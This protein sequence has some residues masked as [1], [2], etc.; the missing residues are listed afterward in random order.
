MRS[1]WAPASGPAI[2]RWRPTTSRASSASVSMVMSR[3]AAIGAGAPDAGA[4]VH[5]QT[6]AAVE[7]TP[8]LVEERQHLLHGGACRSGMGNHTAR[9][10]RWA[11]SHAT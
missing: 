7:P 3:Q 5:Q 2:G 6:L 1:L 11:V 10:P 9:S 8:Q 4:A